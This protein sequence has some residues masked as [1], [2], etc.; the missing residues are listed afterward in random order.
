MERIAMCQEERDWLDWLKRVRDGVITQRNA[1][2]KMG[3]T[4]RWV[5][6]LV[7]RIKDEGHHV[8]MHGL[9]GQPSNRRIAEKIQAKAVQIL[10]QPEWHDFGPTFASEQLAKRH[11][12][13]VS[14]ETTRN[15]MIEAGLW[16]SHPRSRKRF[17]PGVRGAVAMANW[18]SGTRQITTGW[19]TAASRCG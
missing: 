2:E 17:I 7:A 16:K 1:A 8:V 18:C 19:K 13:H 11:N 4:D 10:K 15:W 9:R 3:I 6:A 12:I 5:R 14:K